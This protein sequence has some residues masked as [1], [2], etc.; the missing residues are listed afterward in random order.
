VDAVGV[1]R[2]VGG[3]DRG[4][5]P[6]PVGVVAEQR[7]L[8]QVVA[9]H[10]PADRDRVVLAGGAGDLDRHPLGG[11]LGVGQQ[12]AGEVPAGG[13]ERVGELPGGGRGAGGAAGEHQHGVVGGH[14][15]V[16]VETVEADPYRL[17][18]RG[19]ERGRVGDRVGGEHGEHGGQ[20]R[21]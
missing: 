14:A 12:L 17:A 20:P 11:A 19:V 6:P 1:E 7:G 15:A 16:G 8:D 4:E 21:G 13:G 3:A 2:G 9:G 18:Q 10:G 5:D